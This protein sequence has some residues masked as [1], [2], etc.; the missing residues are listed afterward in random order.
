MLNLAVFECFYD[1][2]S[3][4]AVV[5]AVDCSGILDVG[6]SGYLARRHAPSQLIGVDSAGRRDGTSAR[7]AA[8]KHRVEGRA[9]ICLVRPSD[10]AEFLVCDEE[11]VDRNPCSGRVCLRVGDLN[12]RLALVVAIA[13]PGRPLDYDLRAARRTGVRA[14]TV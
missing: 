9:T 3:G 2:I 6:C 5:L 14:C 13:I 4:P 8:P 12:A 7:K 1:C 11:L 10:A